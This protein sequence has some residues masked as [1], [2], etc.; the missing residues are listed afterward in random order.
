MF[1]RNFDMKWSLFSFPIITTPAD[2]MSI[3]SALDGS[4]S[5]NFSMNYWIQNGAP[6]EKLVMGMPLY[7]RSFTLTK[8][9]K[10][11]LYAPA[12]QPGIAGPYTREAGFIGYNEVSL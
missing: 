5:Q 11:G 12:G 4:F 8:E 10:T 7:G 9:D 6:A 3:F 1:S 2:K